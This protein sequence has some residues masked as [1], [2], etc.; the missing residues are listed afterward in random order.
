MGL[1][2]SACPC[3]VCYRSRLLFIRFPSPKLRR[4]D[5][6]AALALLVHAV[7]AADDATGHGPP[8]RIEVGPTGGVCGPGNF[9]VLREFPALEPVAAPVA[10][11]AHGI[12]RLDQLLG[13]VFSWE[14]RPRRRNIAFARPGDDSPCDA[15][16]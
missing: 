14:L 8:G 11:S 2:V 16:T 10:L 15:P 6:R 1:L 4:V 3:R 12:A 5:E 13:D 9:G 7:V